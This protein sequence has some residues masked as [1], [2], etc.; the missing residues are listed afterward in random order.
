MK[1]KNWLTAEIIRT[2]QNIER[3]YEEW[4]GDS[5]RWLEGYLEGLQETEKRIG[6]ILP[7]LLANYCDKH[8]CENCILFGKMCNGRLEESRR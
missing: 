8:T 2:K 3:A 1:Y 4:D 6:K 7:A 5:A